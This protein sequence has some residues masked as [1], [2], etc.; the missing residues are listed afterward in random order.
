MTLKRLALIIPNT[1]TTLETDL[2]RFLPDH[3][4]IHTMRIWLDEVGEAAEKK[5]VDV[6]LPEGMKYLEGITSFDGAI[7]GCT[8][9]SA[10][11]GKEGLKR[12]EESMSKVFKCPSISA[13]GAILDQ[14]D[15]KDSVGLITPYTDEVNAFMSKSLKDFGVNVTYSNGLGLTEDQAISKVDP[16]RIFKF[17]ESHKEHLIKRCDRLIISCTNFRAMEVR[18]LVESSLNMKT[19]TSN[20]SICNWVEDHV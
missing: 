8:S 16:E 15:C 4:I 13:F 14:L 3:Y 11:Y 10:V 12:L 17:V 9:A 20:Y 2:K 5:M 18:E 19:I 1:D 6:D 7:F